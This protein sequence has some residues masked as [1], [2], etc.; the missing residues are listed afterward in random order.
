M[1]DLTASV[2]RGSTAIPFDVGIRYRRA[3]KE[4]TGTVLSSLLPTGDD[5]KKS[6]TVGRYQFRQD[7]MGWECREI[8]GKGASRRRPY[9][10]YLTRTTYERMQV[11]AATREE[12]EEKLIEW[13]DEKREAKPQRV[14]H[15]STWQQDNSARAVK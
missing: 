5:E 15:R 3:K 6:L 12:L 1:P 7:G 4:T 10:A 8:V 13:A 14:V 9:L 2:G 11:K